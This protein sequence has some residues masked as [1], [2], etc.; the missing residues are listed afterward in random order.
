[1]ANKGIETMEDEEQLAM[2]TEKQTKLWQLKAGGL[3]NR[4]NKCWQLRSCITTTWE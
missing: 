3:N 2:R 4:L 1:M